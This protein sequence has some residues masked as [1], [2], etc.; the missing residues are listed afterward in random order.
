MTF[1]VDDYLKTVGP[2]LS[3][4]LIA[5]DALANIRRIGTFIP[6]PAA[7]FFGFECRLG[8]PE[9]AVDF[10]LCASAKGAGRGILAGQDPENRLPDTFTHPVWIVNSTRKCNL[11][12][13]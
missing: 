4:D 2:Y 13:A 10:L 3:H 7:P 11:R 5:P 12:R 9:A 1:S 8:V 6:G